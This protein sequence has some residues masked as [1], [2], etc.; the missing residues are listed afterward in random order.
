[1]P[2]SRGYSGWSPAVTDSAQAA[3]VVYPGHQFTSSSTRCA[4]GQGF[5]ARVFSCLGQLGAEEY[6][7]RDWR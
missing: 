4:T 5:R 2:T 7:S 6:L 3:A 1:M